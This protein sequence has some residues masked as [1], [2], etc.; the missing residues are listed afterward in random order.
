MKH[1]APRPLGPALGAFAL[2][3]AL[4]SAPTVLAAAREDSPRQA[5]AHCK[6]GEQALDSERFEQAREE[7]RKAVQLDPLLVPAHYGLGRA[8]M[9]LKDYP[10]AVRAYLACRKAFA[11]QDAGRLLSGTEWERRLDDQIRLLEDQVALL[12]SGHA[13]V[14]SRPLSA[15]N[16]ANLQQ[17]IETLKTQRHRRDQA[18]EPTPPWISVALG[19][20]YFRSGAFA[21]AE[22]EYRAALEVDSNVGEAHNNLAVLCLL[23]GRLDEADREVALAEKGGFRV[24]PGLKDDIRRRRG[25]AGR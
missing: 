10:E 1:A 15:G 12:R 17:Q 7:F 6:A 18:S 11:D 2:L 19:G 3:L 20:A 23:S 21:D 22:R 24:P 13:A 4:V 9:A 25:A 8:H 5:L 14:A 16:V